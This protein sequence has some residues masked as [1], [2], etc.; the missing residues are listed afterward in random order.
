VTGAWVDGTSLD[1]DY[2][3]TNLRQTVR[4]APAVREL[5]ARGHAAFMEISPH[6]VMVMSIQETLDE[7]EHRS[8]VT[9]TLRRDEGGLDRFAASV[10][11][12]YV[13]GG[14][15]D[16][17]AF[18]PGGRLVELP[19]YPFQHRRYWADPS[20][21][22][23]TNGNGSGDPVDRGFWQDVERGDAEKLRARLGLDTA[24]LKPVLPALSTWYRAQV[25]ASTVDSWRYRLAWRPLA[26]APGHRL[27]GT[28]L[29]AARPGAPL[30]AG[31]A[32][33]LATRG[34]DVVRIDPTGADRSALGARIREALGDRA[35]VG[36]LSLAALPAPG[37]R[38]QPGN[39]DETVLY[40]AAA[41]TVTLLQAVRDAGVAAPFWCATTAGV[42]TVPDDDVDP[43]ASGLWGLGTVLA[44]DHPDTWGGMIDVGADPADPAGAADGK[45]MDRLCAVLSGS[46]GEDQVAIRPAA[47]FARRLV[48]VP[49]GDAA[50]ARAWSPR[51]T[52]LVTGGTG[53]IGAHV[54][55]WLAGAGAAHLVLTSRRGPA[56]DGAVDLEAELT[57]LG[58]KVT[59][60]AC[61]AGDADAMAALLAS[62]PAEHPVTAVVHAA[63]VLTDEAPVLDATPA[64]FAEAMR[65][66][67][68]GA[69]CLNRLFDDRSLDAFVLF[70]SGAA[71][72]GSAGQP[73]YATA[74]AFLDGLAQRRRARGRPATSIAWGSWAGGGMVT[75]AHS[76]R[77]RRIGVAEMDPALATEA[78]RQALD[79]GESHLVVAD[80]D[81]R[82]FA[83]VYALARSRPLLR[84]LPEARA[85]LDGE[86]AAADAAQPD[87]D[88]PPL[89]ARL[90]ELSPPARAR[91]LLN[92]VLTQ[93]AVVLGHDSPDGVDP[94]RGFKDLGFDSVTAVDLR[95][96]LSAA[97]GLRLPATVVFDYATPKALAEHLR[98]HLDGGGTEPPLPVLAE[99]DR[100]D[101]LV[102]EL[103]REEI[104]RTG[105]TARLQAMVA[106]LTKALAET[107]GAAI[108]SLVQEASA[109]DLFDLLD[110]E[111]GP[112]ATRG[113]DG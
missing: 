53:A 111:L 5:A 2:W 105:I 42:A 34:A 85:A 37:D 1:A 24:D 47:V 19:T 51:G 87:A 84:D 71:V 89:A 56:A 57:A 99:L 77:L 55:R 16:W 15:A 14:P 64:E 67:V 6:P 23:A 4:F 40:D 38:D 28:W 63:G 79:R 41:A 66:K 104:E 60:A 94:A 96:R 44:L 92:L 30:A 74:N 8:V 69:V 75:A 70:S 59:I 86:D 76:E 17:S 88:G 7:M 33:G 11:E 62:L 10:A 102:A 20:T 78:L 95:N 35:A 90:A 109:E 43:A 50:P 32:D 46:D 31:I 98:A 103:P 21:E 48:R 45:T 93:A 97:A 106:R 54:A 81:W 80:F 73:A 110:K 58:A 68:A 49:I 61:D 12:L 108:A 113:S 91:A 29:V 100:L 3:F 52:I 22:R 18:F 27:S 9:G 25:A 107:D 36:V 83:P 26:D 65:G 112:N 82:R 13:H 101:A 39:R 72:W